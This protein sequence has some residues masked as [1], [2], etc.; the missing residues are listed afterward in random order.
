[1]D[2][3][4]IAPSSR[5]DKLLQAALVTTFVVFASSILLI[6]YLYFPI[7]VAGGRLI[8]ADS[9]Y[10]MVVF[11][12]FIET[13][14]WHVD[15]IERSNAPFG[16]S[17]FRSH[18]YQ[19]LLL[20][21]FWPI[22]LFFDVDTSLRL[23]ALLIG[24]TLGILLCVTA[25][26]AATPIL[27]QHRYWVMPMLFLQFPVFVQM[28]PGL[29]DHHTTQQLT[30]VIALGLVI[31]TLTS[32]RKLAF[33]FGA[34]MVHGLGLWIS[35]ELLTLPIMT[36]AC[37]GMMWLLAPRPDANAPPVSRWIASFGVGF[38]VVVAVAVVIE[39][40]PG[41]W[42][43]AEYDRVSVV[44]VLMAALATVVWATID[45]MQHRVAIAHSF[46]GR[47][48]MLAVAGALALAI[49]YVVY[50]NFFL[51]PLAQTEQPLR[52]LLHDV[53]GETTP[54]YTQSPILVLGH[55]G[56]NVAAVPA[57]IWI[58]VKTRDT[59]QVM[60]AW[61]FIAVGL[62]L[63]AL[64]LLAYLRFSAYVSCLAVFPLSY[65]LGQIIEYTRAN[66]GLASG[67]A[68][69]AVAILLIVPG[70]GSLPISIA[71]PGVNP[72]TLCQNKDIAPFLNALEGKKTILAGFFDGPELLY[73][74]RH[75]VIG[76]PMHRNADGIIDTHRIMSDR[77]GSTAKSIID[78]RGIDLILLCKG[79]EF[80]LGMIQY[81]GI[82]DHATLYHQL[83]SAR[84]PPWLKP[85]I[86]PDA[87]TDKYLLYRV[88]K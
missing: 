13:G 72:L 58:A 49:I 61:I 15:I 39:H 75:S 79:R 23:T 18:P 36:Y 81:Q 30:F 73:F 34:G 87:L 53:V 16:E 86:L 6:A 50:P 14:K 7:D 25:M 41:Q 62:V 57:A 54:I 33:A 22:H 76:T 64:L 82:G 51:G 9:Y 21:I 10:W 20:I 45:Q 4:T 42:L 26:W 48:T 74:T 37:G 43:A 80:D 27:H 68:I 63:F 47:L 1:M 2:F 3:N 24:P 77:K 40:P 84:P 38:L 83:M 29:V 88:V 12:E 85:V 28:L 66:F 19:I 32:A 46:I 59:W 44:H 65:V 55:L 5:S 31:R 78:A 69:R 60:S 8:G 35:L 11:R 17:W 67:L 52:S 56:L 71:S 70:A